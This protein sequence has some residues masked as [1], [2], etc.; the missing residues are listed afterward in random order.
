MQVLN[1]M[2]DFELQKMK[3]TES[4]KEY[5]DRLLNIASRISLLG[6]SLP[7]SRIVQKILVTIPEIFEATITSLENTKDMSRITLTELLNALQAQEQRR[8][9]RQEDEIEGALFVKHREKGKN[10]KKNGSS[11]S[12]SGPFP[13]CQHCKRRSHPHFKCWR[14]PEAKCNKCNQMGHE[15]VICKNK[16]QQHGEEAQIADQEEEDQLFVATCISRNDSSESWLIDSGCT[17]HMTHDRSLFK[18]LKQT[19][20]KGTVAILTCSGTKLISDVLYV[21]GI[22]QNLFSV[23]QL[24]EKGYKVVFE[25]N[26]CLIKDVNGHD[27]FKIIMKGKSFALNPLEEEHTA[28]P[29]KEK[30]QIF[31]TR[32]SGTIITEG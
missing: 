1:L 31:G 5:S 17:N 15:A 4:I 9:M 20:S 21:P 30:S 23:G 19:T 14:R 11:Q 6:S 7:E 13:P 26:C 12:S 10:Y 27:I 28:F 3:K 32:G 2:R 18:E 16:I 29:I 24:I 25:N 8:I 22:N